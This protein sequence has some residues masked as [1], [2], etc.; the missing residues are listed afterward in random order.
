MRTKQVFHVKFDSIP[1]EKRP[2]PDE[3]E[4]LDSFASKYVSRD[5]GFIFS[6]I[7]EIY[8][9]R[10]RVIGIAGIKGNGTQGAAKYLTQET[11]HQKSL[12]TLLE[13][14]LKDSDSLELVIT[15][16]VSENIIDRIDFIKADL[17]GK[18]IFDT[19]YKLSELCEFTDK[20]CLGCSFG[21]ETN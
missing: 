19:S 5:F 21:E 14:P 11:T 4:A 15:A 17:N 16:E 9:S 6:T 18:D 12:D 7:G 3:P 13:E 1:A 2:K 20:S 10:R 8:G